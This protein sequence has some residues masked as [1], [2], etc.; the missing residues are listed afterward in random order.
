[1]TFFKLILE[2]V[3]DKRCE[4]TDDKYIFVFKNREDIFRNFNLYS[5]GIKI[6]TYSISEKRIIKGFTGIN[7]VSGITFNP[8][9]KITTVGIN[10]FVLNEYFNKYFM[11]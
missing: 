3:K 6:D 8:K 11:Y 5:L 4:D 7:F 2:G 10:R 9:T 1:M